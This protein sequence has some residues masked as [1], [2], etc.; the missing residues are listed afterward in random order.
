MR[1]NMPIVI[2]PGFDLHVAVRIARDF[3]GILVVEDSVQENKILRQ[4]L[5]LPMKAGHDDFIDKP[6]KPWSK[7]ARYKRKF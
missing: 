3:K 5:I 7:E 1:D 6:E 2:G 4:S